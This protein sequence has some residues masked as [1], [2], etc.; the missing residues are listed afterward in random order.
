MAYSPY[1]SHSFLREVVGMELG[2]EMHHVMT[3]S[4]G[5]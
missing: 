3:S 4:G 2:T 5:V 1:V